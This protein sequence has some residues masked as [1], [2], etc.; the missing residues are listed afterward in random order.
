MYRGRIGGD[1]VALIGI[2][3]EPLAALG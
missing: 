1:G 3:D 2:Y